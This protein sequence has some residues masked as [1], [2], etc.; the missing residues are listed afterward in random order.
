VL[1]V[2][3]NPGQLTPVLR[4]HLEDCEVIAADNWEK[5]CELEAEASL[6]AVLS[7][8]RPPNEA[9]GTVPH[10]CLPLPR[11]VHYEGVQGVRAFLRKPLARDELLAAV[12]EIGC[13]I[14]QVLI[15]D[16]D[17]AVAQ[18]LR[19]M[20][21]GRVL[22]R[23]CKEAFDGEEALRAMQA[24]QPDLV[25]LDLM[26]PTL[27]G[28][29]VLQAM[30][31]DPKLADIPVILVSAAGFDAQDVRLMGPIQIARPQG[32]TFGE[33]IRIVQAALD[34][35]GPGWTAAQAA[36]MGSEAASQSNAPVRPTALQA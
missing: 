22:P 34:V 5:A 28:Y 24:A 7:E 9:M 6:A 18:L 19:R 3:E 33:V 4:R 10:I 1:L 14:R 31:R 15:V 23:D 2:H 36:Q 13:A 35:L 16:N 17:P 25:I 30:S 32:F 8:G 27:D 11:A 21:T 26:M 20:L 12:D 29:G